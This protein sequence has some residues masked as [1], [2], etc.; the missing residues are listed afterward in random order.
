[1]PFVDSQT[2][3]VAVLRTLDEVAG[4][5]TYSHLTWAV[6]TPEAEF[7]SSH[8]RHGSR[9]LWLQGYRLRQAPDDGEA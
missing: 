7:E 8:L 2:D 5:A 9:S 1:M 3:A 6:E 4:H